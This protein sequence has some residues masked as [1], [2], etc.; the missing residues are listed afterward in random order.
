MN[1]SEKGVYE[2]PVGFN[3][4]EPKII[5]LASD[6]EMAEFLSKHL[7]APC[8]LGPGQEHL[9]LGDFYLREA[10]RE[11]DVM[12]NRSEDKKDHKAISILESAV[13][14]YKNAF[15]K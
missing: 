13:N 3:K 9:N 12:K 7:L 1:S 8:S 4:E 10:E 14:I 6:F 5:E 11:L 15:G 2:K